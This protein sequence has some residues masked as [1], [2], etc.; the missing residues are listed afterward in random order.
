[1]R[2][3]RTPFF[4]LLLAT[5]LSGWAPSLQA[6]PAD[7]LPD[8]TGILTPWHLEPP[9]PCFADSVFMIVRG[10]VATPCDSFRY[11][12]LCLPA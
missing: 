9:T 2:T 7:S 8:T 5:V 11:L 1:M 10:F 4:P 3:I 12:F 6:A